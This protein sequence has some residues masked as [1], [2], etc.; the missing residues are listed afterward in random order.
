MDSVQVRMSAKREGR[1]PSGK[2]R[3]HGLLLATCR[4][5]QQSTRDQRRAHPGGRAAD[6]GGRSAESRIRG[7]FYIQ[8]EL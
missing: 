8:E 1:Q 3:R 2:D 4:E 7:A 5:Q 6:L